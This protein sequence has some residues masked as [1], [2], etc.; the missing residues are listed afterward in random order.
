MEADYKEPTIAFDNTYR[1]IFITVSFG[2]IIFVSV[3]AYAFAW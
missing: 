2:L 1:T 3:M